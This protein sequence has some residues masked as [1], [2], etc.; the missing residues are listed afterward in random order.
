MDKRTTQIGPPAYVRVL[1]KPYTVEFIDDFEDA[2][3]CFDVKQSIKIRADMPL[4][5]EQDT[6]VHELLHALDYSMHLEMA[7]RQVSALA[8]GLLAVLRDN[9]SLLHYL[10]QERTYAK[11]GK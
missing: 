7:E 6:V 4:E 3:Q 5:L 1:G 10:S 2:G 8:A 11:K 9:P